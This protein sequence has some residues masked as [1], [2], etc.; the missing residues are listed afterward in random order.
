MA[1][2][3]LSFR[4]VQNHFDVVDIIKE[5]VNLDGKYSE[6]SHQIY[7]KI[8]LLPQLLQLSD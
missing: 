2:S 1:Y 7:L 8:K 4:T 6:E 3:H 5:I